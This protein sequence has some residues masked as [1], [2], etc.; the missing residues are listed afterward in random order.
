VTERD[1]SERRCSKSR[2]PGRLPDSVISLRILAVGERPRASKTVV[3]N[4]SLGAGKA[5]SPALTA[6]R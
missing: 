3:R 4:D 1:P 5:T 2:D 6:R